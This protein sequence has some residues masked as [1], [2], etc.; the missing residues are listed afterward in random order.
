[1]FLRGLNGQINLNPV[2]HIRRQ[3]GQRVEALAATTDGLFGAGP[4]IG[5]G[6]ALCTAL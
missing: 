3:L 1:V 4:C 2:A 5:A 6:S